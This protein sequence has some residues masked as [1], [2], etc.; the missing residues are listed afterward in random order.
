MSGL[1]WYIVLGFTVLLQSVYRIHC[2]MLA[3]NFWMKVLRVFEAFIILWI[4]SCFT[5]YSQLERVKQQNAI[6]ST[7]CN[8]MYTA[9]VLDTSIKHWYMELRCFLLPIMMGCIKHKLEVFQSTYSMF[10]IVVLDIP[11]CNVEKLPSKLPYLSLQW[12]WW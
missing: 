7:C 10:F 5:I 11:I 3:F 2:W 12:T 4:I 6:L 1:G 8:I 9:M